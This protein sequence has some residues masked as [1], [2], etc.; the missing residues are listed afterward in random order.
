MEA[1]QAK[2]DVGKKAGKPVMISM[3]FV[4]VVN[5]YV[6]LG[7]FLTQEVRKMTEAMI[8]DG[9]E[10]P[11]LMRLLNA[12]DTGANVVLDGVVAIKDGRMEITREKNPMV[13][14]VGKA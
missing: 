13:K 5:E 3:D 9:R 4:R 11:Q 1:V 8:R 7:T 2:I 14:P 12:L 6:V 10:A